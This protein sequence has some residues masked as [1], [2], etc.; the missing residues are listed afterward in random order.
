MVSR[1]RPIRPRCE[2]PQVV[3]DEVERPFA[4]C[5]IKFAQAEMTGVLS[6]LHLAECRF[7]DGFSPG[8]SASTCTDAGA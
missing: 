6:D 5:S 7:D 8:A 1:P 3:A 2:L 4:P